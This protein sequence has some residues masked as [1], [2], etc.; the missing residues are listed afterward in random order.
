MGERLDVIVGLFTPPSNRFSACENELQINFAHV[1]SDLM[2]NGQQR[3]LVVVVPLP[4]CL[5]AWLLGG[6]VTEEEE[7]EEDHHE[8]S[9]PPPSPLAFCVLVIHTTLH[10]FPLAH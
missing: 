3:R 7:E 8:E 4:G 1:R 9:R 6:L 10:S 5:A 2:S